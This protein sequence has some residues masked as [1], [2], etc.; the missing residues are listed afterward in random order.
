MKRSIEKTGIAKVHKAPNDLLQ[1]VCRDSTCALTILFVRHTISCGRFNS[2]SVEFARGRQPISSRTTFSNHAR[3]VTRLWGIGRTRKLLSLGDFGDLARHDHYHS[4]SS[5][6]R[7][8][9][10]LGLS[11]A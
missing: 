6:Y 11:F 10:R 5:L 8:Y 7:P 4:N 1:N 3:E 2:P 9:H